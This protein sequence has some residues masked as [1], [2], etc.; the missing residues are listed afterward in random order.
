MVSAPLGFT[1]CRSRLIHIY[2]LFLYILDAFTCINDDKRPRV[3][4]NLRTFIP[5][6][7][8]E[9]NGQSNTFKQ[10][11]QADGLTIYNGHLEPDMFPLVI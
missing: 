8:G 4:G 5:C 1:T 6:T 10:G 2:T 11:N 3:V 9:Y 7:L